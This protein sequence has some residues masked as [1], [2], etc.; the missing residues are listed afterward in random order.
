M[1]KFTRLFSSYTLYLLFWDHNAKRVCE[2]LVEMIDFSSLFIFR[3]KFDSLT[4][5]SMLNPAT[6]RGVS[7]KIMNRVSAVSLAV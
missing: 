4:S 1:S 2:S 7:I 5:W 6:Q 3:G